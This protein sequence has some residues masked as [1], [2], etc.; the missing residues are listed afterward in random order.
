MGRWPWTTLI[1]LLQPKRRVT[2]YDPTES[3]LHAGD[4]ADTKNGRNN[5]AAYLGWLQKDKA[6]QKEVRFERMSKG[7]VMV[8]ASSNGTCWRSIVSW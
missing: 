3:L 6:G 2:W 1:C 5:Y 8:C 4:L 7:W